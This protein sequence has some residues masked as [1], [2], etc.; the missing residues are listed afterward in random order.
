[1]L[2]SLNFTLHYG[3]IMKMLDE[4]SPGL[5]RRRASPPGVAPDSA[6]YQNQTLLGLVFPE[7]FSL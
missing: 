7:L 6:D 4:V 5:E 3:G 2:I 1:M